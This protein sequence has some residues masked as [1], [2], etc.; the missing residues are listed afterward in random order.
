ML[1]S[2]KYCPVCNKE[3]SGCK[4][5]GAFTDQSGVVSED[6]ELVLCR[7]GNPLSPY[8]LLS[9]DE[10]ALHAVPT[11]D[12]DFTPSSGRSKYNRKGSSIEYQPHTSPWFQRWLSENYKNYEPKN[13]AKTFLECRGLDPQ[14]AYLDGF[15]EITK[16]SYQMFFREPRDQ[17]NLP[18]W[19][20][21]LGTFIPC[22]DVYGNVVH[23]QVRPISIREGNSK[24]LWFQLHPYEGNQVRDPESYSY[25]GTKPGTFWKGET[26]SDLCVV[27]EGTLKPYHVYSNLNR[28]YHVYGAASGHWTSNKKYTEEL[29]EGLRNLGVTKILLLPDSN[30]RANPD[31]WRCCEKL[32][33]WCETNGFTFILGDL[34]YK[35]PMKS[36]QT[37]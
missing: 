11:K 15:R 20:I 22:K 29:K 18:E 28:K 17:K 35:T 30:S 6:T 14:Q 27:V 3:N 23:G 32:R 10:W 8:K 31:V 26:L 21:T 25:H 19:N 7:V 24:Y 12:I 13:H 4:A 1:F 16:E 2:L 33:V 5:A 34:T 36:L 37:G 9:D